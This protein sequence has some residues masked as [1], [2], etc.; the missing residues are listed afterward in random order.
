MPKSKI[1]LIVAG[2]SLIVALGFG[3]Y[4]ATLFSAAQESFDLSATNANRA[5]QETTDPERTAELTQYSTDDAASGND[6][7]TQA[8]TF[9]AI[10]A[11]ML[12][13]SATF[14]ILSRKKEE[15]ETMIGSQQM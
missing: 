13:D 5:A 14:F 15:E 8:W 9:A 1:F 12:L 3:G 11:V 2:V 7:Q 6:L 4:S 10:A